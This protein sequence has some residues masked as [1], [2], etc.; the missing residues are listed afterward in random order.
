MDEAT[1]KT[2]K[3]LRRTRTPA[4]MKALFKA[5]RAR[6]DAELLAEAA[7][8]KKKRAAPKSDFAAS[9][10]ARLAVI[11][12]PAADKADALLN[13]IEETHGATGITG[14]GLI[15]VIRKLAARFGEKAVSRATDDLLARIEATGSMRERVT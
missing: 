7:S 11:Q 1:R 4:A 13:V 15:P 10:A 14:G 3:S 2:L 6:S 9:I 5:V 12:G 8:A